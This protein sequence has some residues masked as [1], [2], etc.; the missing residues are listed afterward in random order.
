[1]KRPNNSSYDE[2]DGISLIGLEEFYAKK[3]EPKKS[4]S[5]VTALVADSNI[6]CFTEEFECLQNTE[7]EALTY[8]AGYCVSH[9]NITC[10][11]C[12]KFLRNSTSPN[13]KDFITHMSYKENCLCR[14]SDKVIELLTAADIVFHNM[15]DNMLTTDGVRDVLVTE[16]LKR[17]NHVVKC[18]PN[19]H[20][21]VHLLLH[22]YMNVKLHAFCKNLTSTLNDKKSVTRSS[23]SIAMR[24]AVSNF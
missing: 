6:N 5:P 13:T 3:V 1:L 24:E 14:P 23:K 17:A 8:V 7:K 19:C 12:L 22:K 2:D 20:N 11:N 21:I 10:Q 15:I 9:L 16:T 4:A 18:F